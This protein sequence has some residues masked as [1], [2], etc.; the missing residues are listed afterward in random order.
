[1]LEQIGFIGLGN[2][3]HPIAHNLLAAGHQL[4]VYN[5]DA[6]KAQ[7]LVKEG[8]K[9]GMTPAEVVQPGGIVFSMVSN[10]AALQ[11]IVQGENGLLTRLG[12]G[13]LHISLST[14]SPV[15]AK[16]MVQ[17]H[18][19]QQAA[20][21]SAPV[22][23]RPEA[24]A[25]RKLWIA[26]AGTDEAKKRARPFLEAI[27][28]GIFEFGDAAEEANIVKVCGNFLIAAAQEAMAEAAVVAEKNGIE[29]TAFI[30]MLTQTLFACGI[31]QNYGKMIAERRFTPTGFAMEL[32]LKDINLVLGA[33]ERTST[34]MPFASQLHDRLV[35]GIANG[36]GKMDWSA[37]TL[38]VDE[39]AGIGPIDK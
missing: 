33:A 10:D 38:G 14:I 27:G 22:F 3:G 26:L 7:G 23:G 5:R 6:S 12:P 35:S 4:H 19:E 32:A 11:S 24:A 39:A 36:R 8:A 29:R 28:Q 21:V 2:M 15:I 34:P 1:M 31:Y 18:A 25:A 16:E 17:L 13:G 9:Q 30:D 37:L 20:F